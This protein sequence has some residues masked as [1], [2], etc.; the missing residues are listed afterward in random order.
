MALA[1]F[2]ANSS[3]MT[4]RLAKCQAE[5]CPNFVNK[6]GVRCGLC[7][8]FLSVKARDPDQHCPKITDSLW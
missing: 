8:C 6:N 4:D 1:I 2:G 7:G 5:P 3:L